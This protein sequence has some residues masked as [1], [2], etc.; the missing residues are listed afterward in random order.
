MPRQYD[1]RDPDTTTGPGHQ[2]NLARLQGRRGDQRLPGSRV[3]VGRD[4]ILQR[5]FLGHGDRLV[6]PDHHVLGVRSGQLTTQRA[7]IEAHVLAP[8]QAV[9]ALAAGTECISSNPL[10]DAPPLH[11]RTDRDNRPG[12]L[13]TQGMRQAHSHSRDPI[14]D[15]Q[16]EV[17]DRRPFQL[18]HDLVGCR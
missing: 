4:G 3:F 9:L 6:F 8:E 7:D 15:V 14:A 13:S 1:G 10:A 12:A 2:D 16:V 17:V 11:G 5:Q 18:Q